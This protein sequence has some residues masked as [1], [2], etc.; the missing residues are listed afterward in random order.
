MFMFCAVVRGSA[1][2][3]CVSEQRLRSLLSSI[4]EPRPK[5]DDVIDLCTLVNKF[6]E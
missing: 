3:L 4:M 5:T 1:A 2:D 6:L